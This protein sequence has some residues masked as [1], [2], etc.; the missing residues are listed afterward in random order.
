MPEVDP[1]ARG[2]ELLAGGNWKAASDEF[3]AALASAPSAEALAGLGECVFWLGDILRAVDLR[4]RAY[5]AFRDRGDD[6][7]AARLALWL[8]AEHT[9]ALGNAAVGNGWLARAER[10]IEDIGDCVERGWLLL[11]RSRAASEPESA[12]QLAQ[13]AFALARA[14]G[15]RDLEIAAISQR[16]R[17]LLAMGRTDQGFCCLDEAMAA[18]TGGE[19][20]RP[21]V[22]S[23][24]C[25]DMI[26]A[27]E[28]TMA[29]ERATQWCNVTD[30]YARRYN[31]L[32]LFA[33][34]RV[35]YA[36]VLMALG[37]WADAERELEA[38]LRS[39]QASFASKSFV[40][41]VKLAELRLLQGRD[42]EAEEL[43]AEQAQNPVAAR[44]L[45]M[46]HLAR[47]DAAAAVRVLQRR[48]ATVSHD[49]LVAAPLLALL[50]EAQLAAGEVAPA[51]EAVERLEAIAAATRCT[52]FV[53]AAAFAAA[54]VQCKRGD[55]DAAA[56]FQSAIE[57]Y[58]TVGMPLFV[59][60]ARLALA[61]CLAEADPRSAKE[62]C[63]AAIAAFEELGARRDVDAAAD[64]RRQLGVGAKT[65]PRST[66]TLTN[67]EQEVL[68][69]LGLGLSNAK[70]GARLFISPKTVE[71]HVSHIL[72]KLGV[73][74][75]AAAV[76][77][78][79]KT[80]SPG[81][82]PGTK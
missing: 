59:A 33:F 78:A 8:A 43:L 6:A 9:A 26:V 2:A 16:G 47:G 69:L 11:R 19:V 79:A 27:C 55:R 58:S 3:E 7:S 51:A 57:A 21:D 32:P 77:W 66:T 1:L 75:R 81:K 34:C 72:D 67:R 52:A 70:I 50:V 15:D 49:V 23:D 46:L 73:E 25:C 53:A 40:A 5:V 31:F 10:L 60:R 44:V 39:Y 20:V 62:E 4:Q 35:T 12:E 65:G 24:T 61:R 45:G 18:A 71:H 64:L 80:K 29:I 41:L 42:A 37:R 30:E 63:R 28:R 22:V 17:A 76:A 54:L 38:A 48:L 82:K 74:T 68:A 56:G 36:G 13:E 14:H